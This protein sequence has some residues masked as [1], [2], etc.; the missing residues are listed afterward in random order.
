MRGNESRVVVFMTVDFQFAPEFRRTQALNHS[1]GEILF[2][3]FGPVTEDHHGHFLTTPLPTQFGGD[4]FHAGPHVERGE[5][6]VIITVAIDIAG[7]SD[8]MAALVKCLLAH[9]GSIGSAHRLSRIHR[10]GGP[11]RTGGGGADPGFA[12]ALRRRARAIM[13]C[14]CLD[15]APEARAYLFSHTSAPQPRLTRSTPT[16]G[17]VPAPVARCT[18]V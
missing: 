3:R 1:G 5:H 16:L 14:A 4:V 2:T 15:G 11:R 9:K 13:D 12:R 6:N 10:S 8:R 7:R 18:T 17:G